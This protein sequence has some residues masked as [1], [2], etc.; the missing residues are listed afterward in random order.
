MYMYM[1]T[2]T[3]MYMGH[4]QSRELWFSMLFMVCSVAV[5]GCVGLDGWKGQTEEFHKQLRRQVKS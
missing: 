5:W 2:Y 1:Y 3:Y 4:L